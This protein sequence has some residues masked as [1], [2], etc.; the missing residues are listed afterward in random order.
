M[1]VQTNPINT[2]A[3]SMQP[4]GGCF[5]PDVFADD[6]SRLMAA[7][8]WSRVFNTSQEYYSLSQELAAARR[9][10]L[11]LAELCEDFSRAAFELES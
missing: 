4:A 5:I 6:L 10:A 7:L 1:Q 2:V 3:A 9:H 11:A 8:D